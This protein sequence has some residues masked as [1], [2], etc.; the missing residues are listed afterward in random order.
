[1]FTLSAFADEIS[2]DPREQIGVLKA[3]NIRHVEFRSIYKTNCLA[4]TGEQIDH[5]KSLIDG[6]GVAL[7]ALGSPIGKIPIDSPFEEHLDKFKK[8]MELCHKLCTPN[9]RVFSYYPPANFDGNWAP[10]RDE[11]IRRMRVKAEL[12]A[13][14]KIKL[15]H[16]NEHKIFGDSPQRVADLMKGVDHPALRSAYDAANWVFCGYDPVEGWELTKQYVE[17]FHIKDWKGTGEHE[18]TGRIPG[19][20]DGNIAYSIK[21]AVEHGYDGFAV[22]EPHLRGGGPTGG[23]TGPDLFPLAVEAFRHILH[24]CGGAERF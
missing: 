19:T 12:A 3:S 6:E 11:V 4:L 5:F 23:M 20:G 24:A 22:M 17:H 1:M 21:D 9:M 16:E 18:H 15:F 10:H 13:K 7:S 2:S 8:A 14:E